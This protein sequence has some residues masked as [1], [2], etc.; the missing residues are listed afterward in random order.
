[1]Q[2]DFC[3]CLL[4]KES[5]ELVNTLYII[6]LYDY[7]MCITRREK[8]LGSNAFLLTQNYCVSD[9]EGDYVWKVQ[10]QP[11]DMQ[12]ISLWDSWIL[13]YCRHRAEGL[14]VCVTTDGHT[15]TSCPC[16]RTTNNFSPKKCMKCFLDIFP[17]SEQTLDNYHKIHCTPNWILAFVCLLPSVN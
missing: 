11:H 6:Y 5:T 13:F 4:L 7:N 3:F 1:M 9:S 16:L 12:C 10:L 17:Y 2:I 15:R 14:W 8:E